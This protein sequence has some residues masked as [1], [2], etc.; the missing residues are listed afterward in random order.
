MNELKRLSN[1]FKI[2]LAQV[3]NRSVPSIPNPNAG[4]KSGAEA[5]IMLDTMRLQEV[6][7]QVKADLADAL[8]L[9]A[10]TPTDIKF[11]QLRFVEQNGKKSIEWAVSVSP[12]IAQ[13]FQA[14]VANQRKGNPTFS[15]PRYITQLFNQKM[16]GVPVLPAQPIKIG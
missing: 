8:G 6:G 10:L 16:P 2:K 13:R 7:E 12:N 14:G 15:V 11:T 3:A 5:Q 1:K 9:K 4:P